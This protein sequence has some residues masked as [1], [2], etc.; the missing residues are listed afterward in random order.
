MIKWYGLYLY[1]ILRIFILEGY[2]PTQVVT[3]CSGV[4]ANAVSTHINTYKRKIDFNN[5]TLE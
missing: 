3:P 5:M 4:L 2:S 1:I